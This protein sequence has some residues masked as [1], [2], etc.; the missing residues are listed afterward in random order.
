MISHGSLQL[1]CVAMIFIF[2]IWYQLNIHINMLS[3]DIIIHRCKWNNLINKFQ[4]NIFCTI[5]LSFYMKCKNLNTSKSKD[6]EKNILIDERFK[7]QCQASCTSYP[8]HFSLRLC[9]WSLCC[10]FLYPLPCSIKASCNKQHLNEINV[11]LLLLAILGWKH[12]RVYWKQ[13]LQS[14]FESFLMYL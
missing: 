10:S 8:F 5:K 4:A 7:L 2:Q 11:V 12:I 6:F 14:S 3:I 13:L 9:I 1:Q